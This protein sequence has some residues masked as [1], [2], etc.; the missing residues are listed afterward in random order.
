[1]QLRGLGLNLRSGK[2][3]LICFVKLTPRSAEKCFEEG[4]I[5]SDHGSLL[6]L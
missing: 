1:M 3:V 5:L 4:P 2:F 6:R